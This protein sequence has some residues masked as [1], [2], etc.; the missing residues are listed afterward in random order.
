MI[1]RATSV[2]RNELKHFAASEKLNLPFRA[3]VASSP[4]RRRSKA[5][6]PF[7]REHRTYE[8]LARHRKNGSSAP[9]YSRAK[10]TP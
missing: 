8:K 4:G 7:V 9:P 3:L 6:G 10:G 2:D 5:A 1:P